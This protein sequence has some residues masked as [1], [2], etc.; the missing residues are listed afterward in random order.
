MRFEI[1]PRGRFSLAESA[2]FLAGWPPAAAGGTHWDGHLHLGLT[3]DDGEAAAGVC[4]QQRSGVVVAEVFGPAQ[5]DALRRQIERIFSLDGDGD[6]FLAV[7]RRD[8]V[9]AALQARAPG[10]R[11][12]NFPSPY[13][14]AAWAVI[15]Q[16]TRM[17]QAAAIK[18][19][20]AE[21]LGETVSIHGELRSAFPSPE[22][23]R[24][25]HAFPGLTGQKLERL[26][27]LADAALAGRLDAERLR[28][29]PSEQA[30][31]QMQTLPGIGP[32]GAELILLRGA[33]APDVL[34][35]NE[36]RV[37]CAV[38]QMYGLPHE[39]T[40]VEFAALAEAWRPF[41][42]W[43]CVLL[44]RGLSPEPALP[45]GNHREPAAAM[46]TAPGQRVLCFG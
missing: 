44:R 15:S 38:A 31:T 8:P 1:V 20:L 9:V 46:G 30:L 5:T 12:V 29:L 14:A 18:R 23:L 19:R 33:G 45:A 37:L 3:P 26:R 17:P 34:P 22:R 39:P 40:P 24:Q 11:P 4:L 13:E 25:L 16:R 28:L 36:P 27:A 2:A 41:R 21:Q 32:F 43:V 7:G 42:T 35:R 10:F 6:A